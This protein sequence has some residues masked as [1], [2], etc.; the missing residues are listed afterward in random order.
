MTKVINLRKKYKSNF[1]PVKSKV[2]TVNK[3]KTMIENS[4]WFKIIFTFISI[5]FILIGCFIYRNNHS[6]IIDDICN[7]FIKGITNG[8]YFQIF[9]NFIKVDLL[10]FIIVFF[11]GTS[12]VGTPLTFIPL[13]LKSTYIGLISS[14]MYCEYNLKGILFCLIFIYPFFIITTTSLIYASNESVYMCKYIYNTLINKNTAD[15]ISIQLYLIRYLFLFGINAACI[16]INSF[17]IV[18]LSDKITLL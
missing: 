18:L 6:N 3:S 12:A 13:V 8:S 2:K 7:S 5:I 9:T 14:H 17:M 16:A 1:R 11:I 15:N 4:E 10:Y